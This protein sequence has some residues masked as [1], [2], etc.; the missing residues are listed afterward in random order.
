MVRAKFKVVDILPSGELK[1]ILLTPVYGDGNPE[2]ENTKFWN[3]TP[4]G[5]I[6]LGTV[7]PQASDQF[8]L[9]KEYY[10][11]FTPAEAPASNETTE[12][13]G[14]TQPQ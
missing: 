10:V 6:E 8:E 11:D 2:H 3:Y 7:N 4:S 14:S 13:A 5:R 9:G 1:T 12:P